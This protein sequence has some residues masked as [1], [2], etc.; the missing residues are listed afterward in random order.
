[1]DAHQVVEDVRS[2]VSGRSKR[3]RPEEQVEILN[4]ALTK[5]IEK[6]DRLGIQFE[7][8]CRQLGIPE[9]KETYEAGI[10]RKIDDLKEKSNKWDTFINKLDK[11]LLKEDEIRLDANEEADI[12]TRVEN[13]KDFSVEIGQILQV[14]GDVAFS[15]YKQKARNMMENEARHKASITQLEAD[16]V[17]LQA[18]LEEKKANISS[19]NDTNAQLQSL[20]DLS[21]DRVKTDLQTALGDISKYKE[22]INTY[23]R[24]ISDNVYAR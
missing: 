2:T 16:V 4:T 9:N 24:T 14:D 23:K 18:E 19:L 1:V 10:T 11:L 13:L 21:D 22:E 12:F 7:K 6:I 17:H 20:G 15:A 5:K 3:S 8:I